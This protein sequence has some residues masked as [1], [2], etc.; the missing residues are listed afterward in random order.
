MQ[1]E[2]KFLHITKTGGT[3]IENIANA[4]G[5]KW[6]RFHLTGR[7]ELPY[8]H[9][10]LSMLSADLKQKYD[11]FAVVRNPY[12]RIISEYHCPWI[13]I[14]KKDKSVTDFNA[15]LTKLINYR[16][17]FAKNNGGGHFKE[18]WRYV[19]ISTN[20]HILKFENLQTEFDALMQKYGLNLTL[21]SIKYNPSLPK[22]FT[23]DDLSPDTIRLI[24]EV[25][26][27]DFI[28]FKYQLK[29]YHS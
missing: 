26:K 6:G 29:T 7:N 16:M 8:W 9:D 21:G 2:L 1:K 20:V 24:N 13:G 25:Y 23:V 12:D 15:T 22:K 10:D 18:Q 17:R 5:I 3:T 4:K 28:L 11:W 14:S 27:K 19:D